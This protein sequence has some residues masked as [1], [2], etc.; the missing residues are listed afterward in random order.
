MICSV[1]DVG[2][3]YLF[4]DDD[5][6]GQDSVVGFAKKLGASPC[7]W[8]APPAVCRVSCESPRFALHLVLWQAVAPVCALVVPTVPVL[9]WLRCIVWQL[10]LLSPDSCRC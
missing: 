8:F 2:K 5:R 4:L 7:I 10:S 1:E 9:L 6:A 3:I